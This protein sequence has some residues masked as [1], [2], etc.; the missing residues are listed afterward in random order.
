MAMLLE[1]PELRVKLATA[2][3]AEARQTYDLPVVG[4]RISDLVGSV[5]GRG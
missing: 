1:S 2:A 5:V 3:C 4:R